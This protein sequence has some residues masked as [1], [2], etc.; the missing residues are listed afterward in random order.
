[1]AIN[2]CKGVKKDGHQCGMEAP[3]GQN[4]CRWHRVIETERPEVEIR[5]TIKTVPYPFAEGSVNENAAIRVIRMAKPN[6]PR[7]SNPEISRRDGTSIPNP[8]YTGEE[9]CERIYRINSQGRWDVARCTELGH[10]PFYTVFRKNITEEEVGED[11]YVTT[12]RIRVAKEKRLNVVAV[13][14]NIRHSTGQEVQLA[15]A[16]GCV[17]L[18]PYTDTDGRKQEGFVC[19]CSLHAFQHR[20]EPPCEFRNCTRSQTV[21]TRYG[22][23]CSERH[24]RLVAADK[25]KKILPIGGDPYSQDQ[26]L[27]EREDILGNLNIRKGA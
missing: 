17:P 26:A 2:Q 13:S 12:S 11:G 14:D 23:F 27:A 20:H 7:E 3:R 18:G 21:D 19:T 10:E 9:S 5:A 1:M 24:A 4:F 16:R 22:R 25:Q 15:I 6:C 8:R